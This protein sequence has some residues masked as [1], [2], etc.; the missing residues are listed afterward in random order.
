MFVWYRYKTI[1]I[2][3][4]TTKGWFPGNSVAKNIVFST[5]CN[6]CKRFIALVIV[7]QLQKWIWC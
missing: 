6:F 1:K 5:S 3:K 2:S 7:F 4:Y